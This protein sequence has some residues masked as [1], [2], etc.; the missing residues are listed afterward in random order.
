MT[1]IKKTRIWAIFSIIIS[2]LLLDQ[3]Y[4]NVND[5]YS[6]LPNSISIYKKELIKQNIALKSCKKTN[7]CNFLVDFA[8]V[9]NSKINTLTYNT[10]KYKYIET[11]YWKDAY[12]YI[13][14]NEDLISLKFDE[15]LTKELMDYNK[16]KILSE[17]NWFTKSQIKTIYYNYISKI[18]Y[19]KLYNLRK[20]CKTLR[21]KALYSF[22]IFL[23]LSD[24]RLY[25]LD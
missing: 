23:L 13:L 15:Y 20:N 19:N 11:N 8:K 22:E 1:N 16:W 12:K 9:L 18:G 14:D 7:N 10:K 4:A 6:E 5:S 3:I 2:I 24:V 25:P 17:N 21:L